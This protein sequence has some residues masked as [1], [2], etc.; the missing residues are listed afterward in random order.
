[1]FYPG[2]PAITPGRLKHILPGNP[3]PLHSP[4]NQTRQQKPRKEFYTPNQVECR[5]QHLELQSYQTQ[6]PRYQDKNT[7]TARTMSPSTRAQKPYHTRPRV[8]QYS[9]STRRRLQN[10]IMNIFKILKEEMN[11]S[12][13]ENT[14]SGMKWRKQ[15]KRRKGV[16]KKT[17]AEGKQE[18]KV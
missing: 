9:L 5:Y 10:T 8:M 11:K 7:A 18:M 12:I 17:Q 2:T 6:M 13:N 16:L 1:M 4:K 3:Q 15:L 14:N